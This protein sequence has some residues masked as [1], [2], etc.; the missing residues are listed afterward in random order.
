MMSMCTMQRKSKTGKLAGGGRWKKGKRVVKRRCEK[1]GGDDARVGSGRDA[2]S[3][4]ENGEEGIGTKVIAAGSAVAGLVLAVLAR[5]GGGE[6]VL[7]SAPVS[8]Q[9]QRQQAVSLLSSRA[10]S[11]TLA[12]SSVAQLEESQ[13]NGLPTLLSF[14]A[15]WCPVCRSMSRP[16]GALRSREAGQLNVVQ[17]N[18]DNAAFAEEVSRFS[19]RGVPHFVFLDADG[20]D[21]GEV[22]GGMT[23]DELQENVIALKLERALPIVTDIRRSERQVS[24][25]QGGKD[26]VIVPA[27]STAGGALTDPKAHG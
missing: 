2:S 22:V 14:Y 24:N 18:V 4:E 7:S 12:S 5:G 19:V 20:A 21:R 11:S 25:R 3:S 10:T 17:L 13:S 15:D 23:T 16:L 1:K 26:E 6:S 8:Q 9:Q 27:L